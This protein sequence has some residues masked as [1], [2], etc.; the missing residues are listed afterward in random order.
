MDLVL[1]TGARGF[2][3]KKIVKA[4]LAKGH[5]VVAYSRT[6]DD[7]LK[8]LPIKTIC[9][10]ITNFD[11]IEIA[12]KG[13]D[14]VIHTAS[15]VGMW[16]SYNDFHT[17]NVIGTEN[18]IKACI[19]RKVKKLVYTSTPSVVFGK[20][21]LRGVDE[22]TP[23]PEKYLTHYAQTKSA[24][25]KLVLDAN[26]KGE[27]VTT[28]L[29]PHLIYGEDDPNLLPR[30]AEASRSG[31]LKKV[32]PGHNLVD[33]IYVD[34]AADSHV[35]AYEILCH[36]SRNEGKAYF[37]SQERPVYCWEFINQLLE[38][39]GA[40]QATKTIP[41][42]LAYSVGAICELIYR[43]F[44]IKS[45]VPPMTRFVAL[46]LGK[47]HYFNLSNAKR[48]FGHNPKITIEQSLEIMKQRM[49]KISNSLE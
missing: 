9:G 26:G 44:K 19:N 39:S 38:I 27:L 22:T 49:K 2:L 13:V 45:S 40:P 10:D 32:G 41:I 34:N 24:A 48:D 33:I 4:L 43:L 20:D 3:G 35:K 11:S 7:E 15:K 12:L 18:L 21:D 6:I 14:G 17:T 46:Q 37:I 30:L 16:G 29:R 28:S 31:R 25:E 5:R 42:W 36:G 23:Y 8:A 1:V 47:S